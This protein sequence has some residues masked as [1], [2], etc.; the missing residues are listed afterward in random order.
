MDKLHE[1]RALDE[2]DWNCSTECGG[3]LEPEHWIRKTGTGKLDGTKALNEVDG[4]CSTGSGRLE[5]EHWMDKLHETR[6]LDE[7]DWNCSTECGGRLEPEHWI[8]KT[9]TGKLDGPKH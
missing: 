9:G 8:R 6:A 3:R 4:N 5:L 2:V 7:V 1:T